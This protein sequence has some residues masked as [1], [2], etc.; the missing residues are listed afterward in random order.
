MTQKKCTLCN[1]DK[2]YVCQFPARK[3]DPHSEQPRIKMNP[4]PKCLGSGKVERGCEEWCKHAKR[5]RRDRIECGYTEEM[6]ARHFDLHV[7]VIKEIESGRIN[8]LAVSYET[9]QFDWKEE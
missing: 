9:L 8:N 1:G 2:F 6:A 3:N 4:C 5:L 7:V